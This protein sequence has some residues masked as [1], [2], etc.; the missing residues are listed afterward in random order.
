M[1]KRS[2]SIFFATLF[3]GANIKIFLLV[4]N[5][6]QVKQIFSFSSTARELFN[7][8]FTYFRDLFVTIPTFTLYTTLIFAALL[9]YFWLIYFLVYFSRISGAKTE[10]TGFWGILSSLFVFLGFGC[11]ACGQTL[12]Y[13]LA[14]FF[15]SSGSL[16]LVDIFGNISILLGIV[17]LLFGI[18]KNTKILNNKNICRL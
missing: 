8:L 4:T 15:L 13:S 3:W 7:N 11:V 10:H 2:K 18:R 6:S 12:L 1:H 5:F 14:L 16:F 17:F 9:F